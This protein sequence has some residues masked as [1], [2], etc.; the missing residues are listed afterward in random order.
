ML[1]VADL[2]LFP[3]GICFTM[4][5]VAA[6]PYN[7]MVTQQSDETLHL[8]SDSQLQILGGRM[9]HLTVLS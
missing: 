8:C 1:V 6:L 9:S 3:D 5:A 7:V 2:P 4:L